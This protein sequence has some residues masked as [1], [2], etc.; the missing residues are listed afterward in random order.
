MVCLESWM[1]EIMVLLSGTLPNP[2]LQTSV[3]SLCMSIAAVVWMISFGL[4]GAAS[5]RVSNELGAGNARAARLAVC[6]VVV[7]VVTQA[8]LVGT[9][10]I[11]LRNIWGYAYTS[12]VEVVKQIAIMLPIL[13]AGNLIDALQSVLAGIARGS[14]WQK[15]GAIVY[16]GSCYLVGIPA[17]II[18]AFVLH[19]GVK[20]LWFGIICALIAQAFSLMIITL[21]TDWEKEANKA[22]DRVYK[23]ITP[24]SLVS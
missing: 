12:K 16:L 23:C 6:V 20:G 4:S 15:A 8:I 11:L 14:G 10:M 21:R 1:Y 13:A 17:A 3:L 2:K 22:K 5:V 24:E 7:I 19:T 9:V 18:F